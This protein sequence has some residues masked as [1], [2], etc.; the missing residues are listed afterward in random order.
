MYK[1]PTLPLAIDLESKSILKKTASARSALAELKGAALS[2][3]NQSILINTLSLQE[4][5]DSSAIENIVTTH[6]ELFQSDYLTESFK[7][8]ASKEVH[9]YSKAMRLGYQRVR[10]RK[11]I[12]NS[13][14]LEVQEII[15][16]NRAGYRKLP[17]TE[18][19]NDKTGE[20]VYVPPQNF[21]SIVEH[22]KNLE[23]FINDSAISDLDPLIKM[24][25]IHHQFESI[26]PFYDGNG[27]TGRIL[28]ILYLVKEDLLNIPILYVSRF[29]NQNKSD[30]YRLLQKVRVEEAWEE[31]ILFMLE[32]VE[33][34]SLQTLLVVQQIKDLML[35]HKRAMREQLPKVYSQ[36]L[37]N[38]IFRHPY[39][40]IEFV[41]SELG[42]SR[43]TATKYLDCLAEIG[44]LDKNKP[45]RESYYINR[46]LVKILSN[47][48]E[49][50]P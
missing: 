18:L 6:D 50:K 47:V 22:M 39:T 2:I 33:Q 40:K 32:A 5:K 16:G 23:V 27:R 26:H 20:T 4:A 34:T 35:N 7:T 43:P 38:N 19:R 15:D 31:W 49:P 11:L 12:Q 29:I 21:D 45:G 25:L 14:I 17:G 48:S 30:Y 8:L 10:E 44:L 1:I 24:A 28:N 37:L 42:V 3:P 36:D 13:L 41:V 9:Q 46:E